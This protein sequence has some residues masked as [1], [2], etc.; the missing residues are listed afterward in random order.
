[1]HAPGR[2]IAKRGRLCSVEVQLWLIMSTGVGYGVSSFIMATMKCTDHR[3]F[4][5]WTRCTDVVLVIQEVL[6]APNRVLLHDDL[7][8]PLDMYYTTAEFLLQHRD[9][10]A[11][12]YLHYFKAN[13]DSKQPTRLH[14]MNLLSNF[15]QTQCSLP[16]DN[17]YGILAL[18]KDASRFPVD[19]NSGLVELMISTLLFAFHDLAEHEPPSVN[20][21]QMN[22]IGVANN[23]ALKLSGLSLLRSQGFMYIEVPTMK[24]NIH[25]ELLPPMWENIKTLSQLYTKDRNSVTTSA[26]VRPGANFAAHAFRCFEQHFEAG[27]WLLVKKFT[28]IGVVLRRSSSD[29]FIAGRITRAS[30]NYIPDNLLEQPTLIMEKYGPH[31]LRGATFFP[32]QDTGTILE[33]DDFG[34][35]SFTDVRAAIILLA[36]PDDLAIRK[37]AI[38]MLS[39]IDEDN[40]FNEITVFSRSPEALST[41]T[42]DSE[43]GPNSEPFDGRP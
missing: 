43:V 9:R 8:L 23:L 42:V 28:A 6:L 10:P 40:I 4:N 19:Y 20:E 12:A 5:T 32:R 25:C 7:E 2:K 13:I 24:R 33:E 18:F 3:T 21:V 38:S 1:M 36:L 26:A 16:H 15:Q 34:T 35:V 22:M 41:Q 30:L 31:G 27:D 29:H 11:E 37:I 14:L 39:K 17:V